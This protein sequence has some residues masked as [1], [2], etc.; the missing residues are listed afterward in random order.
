[1]LDFEARPNEAVLKTVYE[2]HRH[3]LFCVRMAY[4]Q[5]ATQSSLQNDADFEKQF[6]PTITVMN[7]YGS[8]PADQYIYLQYYGA[9]A[10]AYLLLCLAW[11]YRAYRYRRFGNIHVRRRPVGFYSCI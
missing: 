2:N 3:G 6:S 9:A 4:G 11:F 5:N 8:L 1:M 7:P 10:V